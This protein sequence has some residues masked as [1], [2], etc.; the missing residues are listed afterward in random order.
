MHSQCPNVAANAICRPKRGNRS[1]R[2]NA[3][4]ADQSWRSSSSSGVISL[5]RSAIAAANE[6]SDSENAFSDASMYARSSPVWSFA[7]ISK[8]EKSHSISQPPMDRFSLCEDRASHR[9][10]R[11]PRHRVDLVDAPILLPDAQGQVASASFLKGIRDSK[12]CRQRVGEGNFRGIG[13]TLIDWVNSTGFN[14]I[15]SPQGDCMRAIAQ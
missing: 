9:V 3:S 13:L 10:R 7:R 5:A 8:K 12:A 15:E 11:N 1:A 14:R 4:S 6:S 2:P